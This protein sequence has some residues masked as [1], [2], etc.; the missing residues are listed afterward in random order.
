MSLFHKILI[1]VLC[2]GVDQYSKL[3]ALSALSENP[4]DVFSFFQFSLAFNEGIAFSVFVPYVMLLF[5]T[6]IFLLG[7]LWFLFFRRHPLL[8]QWGLLFVIAGGLGNFVD[9]LFRGE[10]IDFLSFWN[11]PIFNLADT[12]ITVGICLILWANMVSYRGDKE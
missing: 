11:F 3:W 6:G 12:F 5:L 1:L 9:R 8:E 4:L 10:V 2:I 7:L